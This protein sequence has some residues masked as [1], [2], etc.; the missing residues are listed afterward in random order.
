MANIRPDL[1]A[2]RYKN[3]PA[4]GTL[5]YSFEEQTG[6]PIDGGKQLLRDLSPFT[7]KIL[8]PELISASSLRVSDVN[9]RGRANS[10][11]EAQIQSAQEARNT[12]GL[13]TNS[14][15]QSSVALST[16]QR[17]VSSGQIVSGSSLT[18]RAVFTDALTA[19]D[20]AYQVEQILSVP[21]L[22]LLVNPKEMAI[23]SGTTGGFIAGEN[24]AERIPGQT[25]TSTPT[26]LQWASRRNS[27]AFQNFVSLYQFYRNNGYI[28]DLVRGSRA[29]HM[30][31]ALQITYDQWVYIG[32]I[33]TFSYSYD[34]NMP[35]RL[36]WSMDFTADRVYDLAQSPGVVLPLKAP[37]P[38]PSYPSGVSRNTLTSSPPTPSSVALIL[39]GSPLGV[40][41]SG[42]EQFA[43]TPLQ[44]LLPT[45]IL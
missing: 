3:L 44:A 6:I 22:T 43:E 12:F 42:T 32:H 7:I 4:G 15:S 31:G 30:V 38:N 13:Q 40:N 36:E 20:V 41:V 9:L 28:F 23:T 34:Q 16:L 14:G 27:A 1:V 18:E 45:G 26:G 5:V 37:T 39:N 25:Q 29:H 33:T 24:P 35:N 11:Q 21:P 8:P 2:S 19:A 10:D 17:T